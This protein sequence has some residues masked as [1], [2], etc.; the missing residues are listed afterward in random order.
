MFYPVNHSTRKR[1]LLSRGV[2]DRDLVMSTETIGG[3]L[4]CGLENSVKKPTMIVIFDVCVCLM[5]LCFT[6]TFRWCSHNIVSSFTID[7]CNFTM[8][9]C[10]FTM[11]GCNFTIDGCNFTMDGCNFTMDGCN[12]TMD[13][14]NF[15]DTT[16]HLAV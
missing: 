1:W 3:G 11:D 6:L 15:V 5:Y 13:G 16:T 4:L 9:G 10:N 8:D 2:A 12:F 14:C 7:G